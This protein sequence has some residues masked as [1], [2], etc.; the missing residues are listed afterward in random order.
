MTTNSAA[1][2]LPSATPSDAS[3]LPQAEAPWRLAVTCLLI[4]T[5]F[6]IGALGK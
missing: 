2:D 1:P 5:F 3:T 4:V 6:I